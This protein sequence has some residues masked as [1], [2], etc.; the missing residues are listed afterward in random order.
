MN[1]E[2]ITLNTKKMN[3]ILKMFAALLFNAIV[4]AVIAKML[5]LPA[6][7]GALTLNLVAAMVGAM[8]KGALRAG[9]FTD[10]ANQ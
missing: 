8:P 1:S 10:G 2:R 6:V 3:K 7:A 5:G 9:V 4:G